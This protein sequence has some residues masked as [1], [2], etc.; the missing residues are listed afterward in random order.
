MLTSMG[1]YRGA[2]RGT[3]RTCSLRQ[4]HQEIRG[5]TSRLPRFPLRS[6][7]ERFDE[8]SS[9]MV[10]PL[11]SI[12]KDGV[13]SAPPRC[14]QRHRREDD[15]LTRTHE[16][17]EARFAALLRPLPSW[18]WHR[19]DGA[20]IGASFGSRSR[21]LTAT[22]SDRCCQADWRQMDE[23]H[24][25]WPARL[26]GCFKRT[27]IE[28]IAHIGAGVARRVYGHASH[29]REA[30]DRKG[31]E[32]CVL[33]GH[34]GASRRTTA[35]RVW[36]QPDAI[37]RPLLDPHPPRTG[38]DTEHYDYVGPFQRQQSWQFAVHCFILGGEHMGEATRSD[39]GPVAVL[40]KA[41][42]NEGGHVDRRARKSAEARDEDGAQ[43]RGL[44]RDHAF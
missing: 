3:G 37:V 43:A 42:R 9:E 19:R 38:G 25:A 35:A 8:R 10:G 21:V 34:D 15:R 27:P 32:P 33:A 40:H 29:V 1:D 41:F 2:L 31:I 20:P 39:E 44:E 13:R 16:V 28:I 17:I 14:C 4:S 23:D 6:L 24:A 18:A 7:V 30:R 36:K 22:F 12:R 11:F 5:S 26:G